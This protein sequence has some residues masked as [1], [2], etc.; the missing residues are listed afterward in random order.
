VLE[1][2]RPFAEI[3]TFV[4]PVANAKLLSELA[5]YTQGGTVDNSDELVGPASGLDRGQQQKESGAIDPVIR[6]RWSSLATCVEGEP[7]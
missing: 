4:P 7:F 6:R 5:E 3:E 2:I 1:G